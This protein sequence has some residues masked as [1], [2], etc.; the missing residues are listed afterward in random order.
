MTDYFELEAY[1]AE[2]W[3]PEFEEEVSVMVVFYLKEGKPVKYDLVPSNDLEFWQVEHLFDKLELIN[4]AWSM[5]L[6][7]LPDDAP[8][9]YA[10]VK[11]IDMVVFEEVA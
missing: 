6:S 5:A 10:W 9:V 2:A 1:E 4:T 3:L 7:I 8:E 11:D